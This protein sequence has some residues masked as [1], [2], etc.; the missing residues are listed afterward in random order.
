M[1]SPEISRVTR[2][3][4]QARANYDRLSR[5]FDLLE[6]GWETPSRRIG[7][8]MLAP[9]PG[10]RLLEIGCGT[11]STLAELPAQVSAVGAD[12]SGGMLAQTAARLAKAGR[13]ADLLHADALRLPFAAGAFDA[14]FLAFTLELFDSPEIPA[15]LGEIRR[16][17]R[18]GGRVG[19]V[20]LSRLGGVGWM[21]S[22]YEWAHRR[23]PVV[24]DCRP[25][26]VQR[27][28]EEAG[29][30][31]MEARVLSLT[32]LGVE[33]LTASKPAE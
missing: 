8:K 13:R 4:A 12:L 32:G 29:L 15:V 19:V 14:V 24:V 27:A 1:N 26:Y 5:W 28:L 22:L 33:V 21:Q 17:L 10:E 3:R 23:F 18:A 11:G 30:R 6:G 16:L 7:L 31:V 25:I 2:S 20:S 9:R